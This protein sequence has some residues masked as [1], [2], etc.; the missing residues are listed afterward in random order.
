MVQSSVQLPPLLLS[1]AT[2]TS[3]HQ[4]VYLLPSAQLR[5]HFV[6]AHEHLLQGVQKQDAV[7]NKKGKK[8]LS[9]L[10]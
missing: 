4:Q 1:S 8:E 6:V 5:G 7:K 3:R 2:S 10:C 9:K